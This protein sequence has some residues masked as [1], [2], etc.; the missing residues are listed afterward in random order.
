MVVIR[1]KTDENANNWRSRIGG[2]P[3]HMIFLDEVER[4]YCL[5]CGEEMMTESGQV[6]NDCYKKTEG[7]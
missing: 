3:E 5:G 7:N 4:A 1:A 6:C 2:R